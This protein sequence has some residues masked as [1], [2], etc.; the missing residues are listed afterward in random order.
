[1]TTQSD[2]PV[3]ADNVR[4]ARQDG[5]CFY[6]QAALGSQHRADCVIRTKTVVVEVT[7]RYICKM[8]ES[9][10]SDTIEF[11]M[12]DSSSCANNLANDIAELAKDEGRCLCGHT[13]GKFIR[14]ATA[15][16]ELEEVS[17]RG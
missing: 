7:F 14:E 11:H 13:T 6:C 3:V 16:D 17:V 9:W 15:E 12:N 1:M 4:P 2:W 5:T 8:P 10:S